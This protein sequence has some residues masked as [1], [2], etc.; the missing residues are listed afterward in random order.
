MIFNLRYDPGQGKMIHR[1][2]K[3]CPMK[4]IV[5]CPWAK[6]LLLSH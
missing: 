6:E 5:E 2:S 4:L 3:L 1:G